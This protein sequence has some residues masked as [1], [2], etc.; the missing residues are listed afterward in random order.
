MPGLS[1][2][3]CVSDEKVLHELLQK[4]KYN[5]IYRVNTVVRAKSM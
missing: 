5:D 4:N 2:K 3:M 1:K